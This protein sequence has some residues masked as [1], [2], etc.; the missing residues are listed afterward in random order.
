[1]GTP[2]AGQKMLKF[3]NVERDMPEKRA[4]D[5]RN[6][7]FDEIY[8]AYAREKAAEQAK[9]VLRKEEDWEHKLKFMHD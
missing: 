2:M 1:M 4:P 6:R 8:G 5:L 3:T 7:D 9:T